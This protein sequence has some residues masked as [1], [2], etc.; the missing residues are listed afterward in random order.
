MPL[1]VRK[2]KLQPP[3]VRAAALLFWALFAFKKLSLNADSIWLGSA[4]TGTDETQELEPGKCLWW[5]VG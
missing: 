2:Q 4:A 5:W 3:P 1:E